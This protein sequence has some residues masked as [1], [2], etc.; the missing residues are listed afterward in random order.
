MLDGLRLGMPWL[1]ELD[2]IEAQV[3]AC[4]RLGLDF[5]ELAMNLPCCIPGRL[6]PAALRAAAGR[7]AVD[8]TLHL[9]EE[10]DLASF[11][12]LVRDGWRRLCC[13]ALRWAAGAGIAVLNMH[14]ARGVYF[15]LPDRR[16]W[17]YEL[18]EREFR[19]ALGESFASLAAE[20]SRLGILLCIENTGDWNEPF[21]ARALEGLLASFDLWLTW[22]TGHDGAAG[23]ADR[24]LLEHHADRIR[25]MH[26][27]DFRAGKSHLAL[28]DGE[29]D[30]E[31]ALAAARRR[32]AGVVVEV[33]TLEALE[34]SLAR[35]RARRR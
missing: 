26:L 31:G 4:H 22:D 6:E 7:E 20:A 8:F 3:A 24:A 11:Q 29:L 5:V 13:E 2:G 34:T 15:T 9:P 30:V 14:L 10:T 32:G 23:F 33:K 35:L 12:P 1:V 17:L 28:Y 21:L 19:D 18:Y 16:A 25:H 27:H